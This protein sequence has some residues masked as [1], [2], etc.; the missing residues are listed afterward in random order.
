LASKLVKTAL[1][2]NVPLVRIVYPMYI[3]KELTVI[4]D[5]GDIGSCWTEDYTFIHGAQQEMEG[6]G[7]LHQVITYDGD[8][9]ALLNWSNTSLW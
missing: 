9:C 2:T 6:F 1:V 8:G 7:I 3:N 5:D 4:V